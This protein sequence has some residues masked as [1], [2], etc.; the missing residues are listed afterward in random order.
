M[1]AKHSESP[2]GPPLPHQTK[3]GELTHMDLWGKYH[4]ASIHS[5]YYYLLMVDNALWHITIKFLKAKEQVGQKVINYIATLCTQN[6]TPCAIR[7]D[8]GTKFVNE[9]LQTWCQAHGI[10]T[11]LTAPYSPLQNG[12]TE[13]MNCTLVELV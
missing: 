11:Q 8:R 3:P 6:K 2:Y 12:V 10:Q 9:S 4:I 7:M 13:W 5:N 1:E